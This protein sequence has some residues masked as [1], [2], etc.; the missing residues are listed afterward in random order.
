MIITNLKG[1]LGNQMFQYALAYVMHKKSQ[2]TIYCDVRLQDQ[3]KKNP[4]PRNVPRNIELDLFDIDIEKPSKL[5]LIKVMQFSKSYKIRNYLSYFLD[6]FEF[7]VLRER[8]RMF[9]PRI[10]KYKYKN[11]YL[12]G[13]WQSEMYFKDFRNDILKLFNF[14]K[15]IDIEKNKNFIKNL[16][17]E[18][19][20]CVNVR[21]TD[22]LNNP[23]HNV[24]DINYYKNALNLFLN[25]L[26]EITELYIFS[27]DL[28]W[29]KK[30][31]TFFS[32][33]NFMDE[34]WIGDRHYNYMYLM[35]CFKNFIIPNS[36][37]A[38]WGAWL[39]NAQNKIVIAP[40]N[41]SGLVNNNKIDTVPNSWIKI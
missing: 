23:E 21:R 28:D 12:D 7:L 34:N 35:T 32:K 3:Y 17:I 30:N 20:I 40:K 39:S 16:D 37:F 26:G 6:K 22:F 1:G 11:L 25:K 4:P 24:V 8:V 27:D 41:W 18:K 31:F 15:L 38:W 36:S 19:S 33:V 2:Q 14:D 13:Y 10:F 5:D 29:C 9:E